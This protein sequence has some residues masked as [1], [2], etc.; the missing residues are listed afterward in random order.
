[1]LS[2]LY[3]GKDSLFDLCNKTYLYKHRP[4]PLLDAYGMSSQSSNRIIPYYSNSMLY[5]LIMPIGKC[6]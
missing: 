2:L 6:L 1:M 4:I 3:S 5:S